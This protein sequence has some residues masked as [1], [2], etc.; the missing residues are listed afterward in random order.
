MTKRRHNDLF[1]FLILAASFAPVA[2]V[3]QA[4]SRPD[5]LTLAQGAV[6]LAVRGT[7]ADRAHGVG[8]DHA[9]KAVDGGRLGFTMVNRAADDTDTE[10][11]YVLP[12]ATVFDRFA[13][14]EVLETP[15]PSQTFVRDVE[16][17]GSSESADGP[18]TLLASRTLTTHPERGLETELTLHA[19]T[20]VRWVRLRM[21]GGIEMLSD[22]MFLE[23][24]EIVGEGQQDVPEMPDFTGSWWDRGVRL[25]LNQQG[26]LVT[27]CYDDGSGL[28]GSVVGG[29]LRAVGVG[30][31][32]QVVS[33]FVLGVTEDGAIR[34][35]RSTNG[36]PFTLY[37][38]AP[39]EE[40]GRRVE[41]ADP[42]PPAVGC[43]AVL[44]GISFGFDSA[45]IRPESSG[46]LDQV[47]SAL[48][49]EDASAVVIEGHTSS[50]G[51]DEYNRSLSERRAASVVEALIGRGVAANRL[52]SEG[53]GESRPIAS[54]DDE[55]GRSMNRRV[56]IR[57]GA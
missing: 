47:A 30:R 56:E 46:L 24:S 15:S 42:E 20:P 19:R 49:T 54:N 10:L 11:V 45:E 29:I 39:A 3:A 43:G 12:A 32:D 21:V 51:S 34:G 38:G 6:P 23:F 57:C 16:V 4:P 25:T 13:V 35:V 44:H 7:G 53:L 52:R 9:L 27:G 8:L 5:L 26:T 40:G 33:H 28:E 36:A 55:A 17:F 22:L 41:C 2:L 50:E 14:P 18:W 31:G 48:A 1:L 37:T